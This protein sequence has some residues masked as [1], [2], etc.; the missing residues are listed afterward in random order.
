[1]TSTGIVDNS[2]SSAR[3]GGYCVCRCPRMSAAHSLSICAIPAPRVPADRCSC[4]ARPPLKGL[5]GKGV[6]SVIAE[7]ARRAG[8]GTV[9]AHRLRHSAATTV[10]AGG[11]S[12]IEARELLGHT[13]TDTTMVYANPREL[14]QTGAL[15]QV[16]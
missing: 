2:P 11:G 1:M 7:L 3:A 12:L 8:L 16:A 5:T 4:V 10:L 9:H 6:S 13:R 15:S 14:H